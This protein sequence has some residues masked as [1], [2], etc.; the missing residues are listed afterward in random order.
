MSFWAN[1]YHNDIARAIGFAVPPGQRV[2][3]VGCRHTRYLEAA[4]PAEGVGLVADTQCL[5]DLSKRGLPYR[6]LP[7]PEGL[8]QLDG[9]FDTVLLADALD[10]IPDVQDFLGRLK[11]L[12]GPR[13]RLI[14][15]CYSRLWQPALRLAEALGMKSRE[16]VKNWLSAQDLCNLLQLCGMP[17]VR[18]APRMLVPVWVPLLSWLLNRVVI[19]LPGCRHLALYRVVVARGEARPRPAPSLSVVVPARNEA[20]NLDALVRRMPRLA[21]ATEIVLVEGGSTDGTWEEMERLRLAAAGPWVIRTARQGG[22]GKGDAV[23]QGFAM[24][25]GELLTILDA[26]LSVP[27]EELAR[28]YEALASGRTEF[29]N[30]CRLVYRREE[31]AMR[32]LNMVGN[33]AFSLLFS[34]LLG[35]RLKDTLCGTKMLSRADYE[36]IA[37]GR[38]DFGDFDPFGDFDLLFGAARLNLAMHDVPVHYKSRRYGVTNI[39]RWRH[40][41]LLLRMALF[42]VRRFKLG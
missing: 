39:R 12:T 28:F 21:G 24:A 15:T 5:A 7:F 37:A 32:F 8:D 23:R 19:H 9:T 20:G 25:S 42:A 29:A 31:G 3:E 6:F 38:G 33:H 41:W 35:Q 2:L 30:G 40:G 17:V 22:T 14:F 18:T 4:R 34:W 27:P 11:R 10:A 13:T 36:R 26:D 1:Y 16:P